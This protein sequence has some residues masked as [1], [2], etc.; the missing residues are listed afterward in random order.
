MTEVNPIH[1]NACLIV[2]GI[3]FEISKKS[4]AKKIILAVDLDNPSYKA[5]FIVHGRELI[6]SVS[7]FRD[8]AIRSIAENYTDESKKSRTSKAHKIFKENLQIEV[9]RLICDSTRVDDFTL[10]TAEKV[11]CAET[12]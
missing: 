4:N 10:R 8:K 9:L 6:L 2:A 7:S 11:L 3:A 5:S 1:L 12:S